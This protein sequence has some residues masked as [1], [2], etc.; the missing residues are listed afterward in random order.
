[1]ADSKISIAEGADPDACIA[2]VDRLRAEMAACERM[3]DIALVRHAGRKVLAAVA[4]SADALLGDGGKTLHAAPDKVGAFFD[5]A[6]A[7][8]VQSVDG[9]I[10]RTALMEAAALAAKEIAPAPPRPADPLAGAIAAW[11][12]HTS[13]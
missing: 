5:R 4:C 13:K 2:D 6:A 11:G 7:G 9:L 1:M 3:G 8:L 10:K 12:K